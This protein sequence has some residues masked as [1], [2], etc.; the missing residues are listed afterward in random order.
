M[1]VGLVMVLAVETAVFV[2]R[3]LGEVQSPGDLADLAD[4]VMVSHSS[5]RAVEH[6][7][8]TVVYFMDNPEQQIQLGWE[9]IIMNSLRTYKYFL[10][11]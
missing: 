5:M 11:I 7:A 4:L 8:D 3:R 6:A 9:S 1:Y 10:F 2:V